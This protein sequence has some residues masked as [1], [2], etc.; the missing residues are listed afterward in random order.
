MGDRGNLPYSLPSDFNKY[1]KRT[2]EQREGQG[3]RNR[4][5][6][7]EKETE[8]GKRKEGCTELE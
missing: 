3:K 2:K 8:E 7:K 5:K 6:G 1:K 4:G